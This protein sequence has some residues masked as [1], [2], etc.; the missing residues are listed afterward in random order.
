MN[1]IIING[2]GPR[3]LEGHPK[4]RV[5]LN[6]SKKVLYDQ[7]KMKKGFTLVNAK[8]VGMALIATKNVQNLVLHSGGPGVSLAVGGGRARQQF[9]D[10]YKKCEEEPDILKKLQRSLRKRCQM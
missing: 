9:S 8:T 10:H 3:C 6:A 5:Y 1:L 4:K 2:L 7:V